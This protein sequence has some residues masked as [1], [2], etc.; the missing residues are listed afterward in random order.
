M[1][2]LSLGDLLTWQRE[3]YVVAAART[4]TVMLRRLSDNDVIWVDVPTM[5]DEL[6]LADPAGTTGAGDGAPHAAQ[7]G[8]AELETAFVV[9]MGSSARTHDHAEAVL[10]HRDTPGPPGRRHAKR[11]GH[12]CGG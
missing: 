2:R 11:P 10:M 9:I 3:E 8:D 5:V 1:L 12:S 6:M 4:Q 7:V